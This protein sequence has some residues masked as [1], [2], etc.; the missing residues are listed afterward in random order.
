MI[1]P[2]IPRHRK[3]SGLGSKIL[4]TDTYTSSL[5]GGRDCAQY[6]YELHSPV[7]CMSLQRV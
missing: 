4:E 6:F 1:F 7:V 2:G 5:T 3:I